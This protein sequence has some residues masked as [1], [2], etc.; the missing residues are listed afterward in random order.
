MAVDNYLQMRRRRNFWKAGITA[1]LM[2]L[3]LTVLAGAGYGWLFIVPMFMG[4]FF[5]WPSHTDPP[6]HRR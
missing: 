6:S 2:I 5:L 3:A 4:A 1:V